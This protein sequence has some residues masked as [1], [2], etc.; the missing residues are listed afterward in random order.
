LKTTATKKSDSSRPHRFL[1]LVICFT[2]I[3]IGFSDSLIGVAWPAI[4]SEF[5]LPVSYGGYVSSAR[6]IGVVLASYILGKIL[7]RFSIGKVAIAA[8]GIM[9][10]SWIGFA[11]AP[12]YARILLSAFPLGFGT[13]VLDS[14]FNNFVTINYRP[15]YVNWLQS[16]FG[17]GAIIAPLMMSG[18]IKRPNG[19]RK[20]YMIIAV[21]QL[22]IVTIL[23]ATF[24]LWAQAG[25]H[26]I[27]HDSVPSDDFRAINAYLHPLRMKGMPW[28]A[29]SFFLYISIEVACSMWFS[30]FL[31]HTRGMDEAIAS[32][33]VAIFFTGLTVSRILNGFISSRMRPRSIIRFSTGLIIGGAIAFLIPSGALVSLALVFL[34]GFGCGPIFATLLS[35]SPP[36]FG[37]VGKVNP[38][39]FQMSASFIGGGVSAPIVGWLFKQIGYHIIPIILIIMAALLLLANERATSILAPHM[40]RSEFAESES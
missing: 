6:T 27:Y 24:K 37:T 15:R 4:E 31:I 29:A 5:S 12:S 18:L 35:L 19:W 2:F 33:A 14:G 21:L 10:V 40:N 30:T 39:G 34:V 13:G 38:I 36:R 28:A 20:L 16:A 9:T 17:I 11:V 3:S 1:L 32:R 25:E 8:A 23:L 7:S 26:S 22:L